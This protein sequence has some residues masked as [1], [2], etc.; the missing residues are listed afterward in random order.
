[1]H[2]SARELKSLLLTEIWRQGLDY[3]SQVRHF[4]QSL[5][6]HE[7]HL[8]AVAM[9]SSEILTLSFFQMCF[10]DVTFFLTSPPKA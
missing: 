9:I 7:M 6:M 1:M 4:E 2:T 10:R 5:E 8:L 3:C